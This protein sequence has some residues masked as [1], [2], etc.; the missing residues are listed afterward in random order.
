MQHK[1]CKKMTS[2]LMSIVLV[3]GLCPGLAYAGE[4]GLKTGGS[5]ALQDDSTHE[6]KA[7]SGDSNAPATEIAYDGD[8]YKL[9]KDDLTS[10]FGMLSP[11]NDSL[12]IDRSN[13]KI[14]VS[15]EPSNKT[16]YAGVYL[17]ASIS[18]SSTWSEGN[19]I[20]IEKDA[21][22]SFDLDESYAGKAWPI[23]PVKRSDSTATTSAQYYMAIPA[24]DK[25]DEAAPLTVTNNVKMFNVAGAELSA[26]EEY[27]RIT[28]GSD[29]FDNVA[30]CKARK[31]DDEQNYAIA[32]R[33]VVLP[34]SEL[35]DGQ[36][37]TTSWWSVNN[38]DWYERDLTFN[39]QAKTL[40][41]DVTVSHIKAIDDL[42]T[43]EAVAA[44]LVSGSLVVTP[45]LMDDMI[46]AIQVQ[47]RDENT[48]FYCAA[49]K[50]MW[51]SMSAE[52]QEQV[53]EADYFARDTGDASED[54]PLNADDI[55]DKEILVVSF[56]TS[57]NDS[58][59]ATIG[60]VEKAIA[61]AF[62]DWS[63]RRA[64]TAQIIINHIQARDGI[65]IDN[66]EQ[67]LDRAVANGVTDLIVA[68]THLMHGAEY[69]EL[70]SALE[71]YKNMIKNI[72]VSEP[73]L[74]E[75]GATATEV[76]ADKET[77]AKAAV[78]AMAKE[79][80]FADAAAAAKAGTAFVFMGHGTGHKASITYNQM[81]AQMDKLGYSNVFIGTVEG[82][83]EDTECSAVIDKVKN[84]GYKNVILRPLMV[85]AGDHANNDMADPEDPDSWISQFK[86]AGA[87]D[88]VTCQIN[89]LGEIPAIQQVYV[90][91]V[92]DAIY[93]PTIEKATPKVKVTA[94]KSFKAKALK[95]KAKSF[96]AIKLVT[97]GK[98]TWKVKKNSNKKAISF[99]AGKVTV[100]KGTAKG[101]YTLQVQASAKAGKNY[102]ALKAKTYKIT[103]KVK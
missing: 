96:V 98:A 18:D 74:G 30:L 56:G 52:D 32:N 16:V 88:D 51:D 48:D 76:N 35:G 42:G 65:A 97:D 19:Y 57:F 24:L 66:M 25:I 38:E 33:Q 75:V 21:D 5:L 67:A 10:T 89:G 73:L 91:H 50:L 29:S 12:S 58:R 31:A 77:V 49:A 64:F 40:T 85:V 61:A 70:T 23:A 94:S 54:D 8:T 59:V 62:P 53:E 20:A 45:E 43:V 36:R 22:I 34:V 99:K 81:Q 93:G 14:H 55:G 101:T 28:M 68:P 4:G 83:P 90:E 71:P 6:G 1:F 47:A 103:V 80:G 69:D 39:A 92:A 9:V 95:K 41:F 72:T 86:A 60:G 27:V 26:D 100:K 87:F 78:A 63:V 15:Y 2:V 17:K 46:A 11:V 37:I 7:E 13:G 84:A 79:A 82:E 3:V 102:E 44:A